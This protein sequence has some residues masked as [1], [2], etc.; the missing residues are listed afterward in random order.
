VADRVLFYGTVPHEQMP[1][2][3]RSADVVASVPL[4]ESFGLVALEA[5][6]CGVPVVASAVGGFADTLVDDVTG[7]LVAPNQPRECA[8]AI[9]AILR[10]PFA[11][12]GFGAVGRDRARSRY[13]WDR[14]AEDTVRVY[15][16]LV[17]SA[18]SAIDSAEAPSAN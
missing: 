14:I 5:M 8:E 3:L 10:D 17:P 16:Q 18:A 13:S 1:A 15:D 11:R 4:R 12:S 9:L 7:R 6:A 2:V